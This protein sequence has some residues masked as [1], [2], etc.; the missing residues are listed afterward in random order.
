MK[1]SP[2]VTDKNP[3]NASKTDNRNVPG[4]RENNAL[5]GVRQT[6]PTVIAGHKGDPQGGPAQVLK[7]HAAVKQGDTR[8][9]PR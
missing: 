2:T 1:N 5:R 3:G 9:P 4:T 8:P 6:Q 7:H